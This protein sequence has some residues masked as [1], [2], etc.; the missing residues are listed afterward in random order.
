M[1][2]REIILQQK[3]PSVSPVSFGFETCKPSHSHGPAVRT[4]WL[5]H[6]V[7]AGFGSFSIRGRTYPVS[8]GSVFVIPP[9][10]EISYRAD[11]KQPW[12]YIWIGFVA[13]GD[14]PAVFDRPV[15]QCPGA[16]SLFQRMKT[17]RDF[18][19]GRNWFLC[20]GLMELI[21]LLSEQSPAEEDYVLQ[22]ISYM[23]AEFAQPLNVTLLAAQLGID[24]SYFSSL[25]LRKMGIS[26]GKFLERLRLEKAAELLLHHG[27]AVSTAALSCGYQD[28]AH[29]SKRFKAHFGVSPREFG[30]REKSLNDQAQPETAPTEIV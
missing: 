7:Q 13:D 3:L 20:A 8:P 25:F 22:A 23:Q 1:A 6:Y 17:C 4:H 27:C 24:R 15:L 30:S 18:Q 26:P 9:Y 29:F 21:A 11:P 10:Q 16:G 12:E 14:M 28:Q 19:N 2:H 5:L